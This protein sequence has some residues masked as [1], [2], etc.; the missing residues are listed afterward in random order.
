MKP[1]D[2]EVSKKSKKAPYIV[3][4]P[5]SYPSVPIPQPGTSYNPDRE[6]HQDILGEALAK[7][8]EYEERI[9]KEKELPGGLTKQDLMDQKQSGDILASSL[10]FDEEE[11]GQIKT[12]ED[13]VEDEPLY[14]GPTADKKKPAAKRRRQ[15]EMEEE[16]RAA[17]KRRKER[18]LLHQVDESQRI[19]NTMEEK[20]KRKEEEK[21]QEEEL[22]KLKEKHEIP[23]LIL[24]G[25]AVYP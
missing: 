1:S 15:Q 18:Q 24:G 10:L 9:Q 11:D 5:N 21:I 19:I 16:R 20:E 25:V 23:A 22:K 12:P 14:I 3:K 8:L 2:L 7:E 6:Q 13:D 4:K 17:E